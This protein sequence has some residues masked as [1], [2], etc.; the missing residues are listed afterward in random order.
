MVKIQIIS[1]R[2]GV[3]L[4]FLCEHIISFQKSLNVFIW[5]REIQKNNC[6]SKIFSD[7]GVREI[8]QDQVT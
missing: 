3:L 6:G 8:V 4:L 1:Y 7:L 5:S 2:I